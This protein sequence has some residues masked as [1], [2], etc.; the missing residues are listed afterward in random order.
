MRNIF[1]LLKVVSP[2]RAHVF[3]I[4][5]VPLHNWLLISAC[6]VELPPMG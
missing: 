3:W 2:T 6:E 5:L 4:F 1:C